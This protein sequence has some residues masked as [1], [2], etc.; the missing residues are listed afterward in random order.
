MTIIEKLLTYAPQAKDPDKLIEALKET[1]ARFEI[2]TPRRQRYFIAQ[3]MFETE[4]FTKFVEV[5]YYSTPERLVAVWPTRFTMDKANVG[6]A[7]A[8]DYIKNSEKLGNLVYANRL[9]NKGPESGDGFKYRGRGAFHL[10]FFDNYRKCSKD[11][12]DD[13]RFVINPDLVAAPLDAMLTAGWFWNNNKMNV[14]ADADMFTKATTV[15]NGSAVTVPE[16]LKVLNILNK[17]E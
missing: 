17:V 16:R 11:L 4:N 6:K 8:P 13:D 1:C 12:Y 5:L 3:A 15:I 10:T 9:G 7:W 14:L 2:N